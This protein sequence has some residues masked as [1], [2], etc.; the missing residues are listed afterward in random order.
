MNKIIELENRLTELWVVYEKSIEMTDNIYS[1]IEAV[2]IK[3]SQ[4][5]DEQLKKETDRDRLI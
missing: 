4:L 2:E 3:I 5:E 1:K